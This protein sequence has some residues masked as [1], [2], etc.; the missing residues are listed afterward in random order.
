MAKEF[1]WETPFKEVG[2]K[3]NLNMDKGPVSVEWFIGGKTN[4][5]YNCLD[6]IIKKGMGSRT[7][8]YYE[9]NDVDD[10]HKA[11]TYQEVFEQ[12]CKTANALKAAGVKKGDRVTIYLPMVVELPVAMLA[13][14][15]IGAIHSVVFGGFSADALAG[16]IH[17]AESPI[18][19]T[20][21]GVMRG[22]KPILLKDISD[23]AIAIAEKDGVSVT[24]CVTVRRLGG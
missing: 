13:C 22:P 9:C 15:R 1:H 12:V 20:A 14:A 4:I 23:K 7:A 2:P 3:Y 16:R 5:S 18:L 21:D 24:K 11:F 10:D 6:R 8:L 17:D 19:I